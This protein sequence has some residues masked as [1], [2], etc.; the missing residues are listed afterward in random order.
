M[1]EATR[2]F[3]DIARELGIAVVG[4]GNTRHKL[5]EN[6]GFPHHHDAQIFTNQDARDADGWPLAWQLTKR[7]GID[8]GCGN[9]GQRQADTSGLD[10]GVWVALVGGE[11]GRVA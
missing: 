4:I 3:L 2:E 9:T 10:L 6:E 11:W 7:A 1:N 8:G 5:L